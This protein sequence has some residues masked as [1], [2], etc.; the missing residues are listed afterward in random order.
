MRAL[1]LALLWSTAAYADPG[2]YRFPALHEQTIVFTA[3]G[4]L[5]VAELPASGAPGK[6]QARRLTT[7]PAEESQAVISDDGKSIAFVASY[8]GARDTY[9]M[10]ITGGEPKRISFDAARV[11]PQAFATIDGKA[12][13]LQVRESAPGPTWRRTLQWIDPQ[14]LATEEIPLADVTDAAL[15]PSGE[16][17]FTR[18]GLQV[19]GDN[20]RNYR[21]GALSEL[22]RFSLGSQQEAVRLP[23]ELGNL[24]RPMLAGDRLLAISDR[25]GVANLVSVSL[26]GSEVKALTQH[27]ALEVRAASYSEGRVLYQWGADLRLLEL[28]SG[29]DQ[30]LELSLSSDFEQ[31]R[32]RHL[33]QALRFYGGASLAP[34]GRRAWLLA[35]GIALGA[36]AQAM[37]RITLREAS[38]ARLREAV[39]SYDGKHVYAI[40]DRDGGTEVQRFAASGGTGESVFESDAHI[41]RLHIA[42]EDAG[43]IAEDKQARLIWLDLKSGKS[44]TLEQYRGAGDQPYQDLSFSSDGKYLVYARPNSAA[45]RSQIVVRALADN[46]SWVL[47]S[48]RYESFAPVFSRDGRWLYFLS[49]RHFQPSP[50]SPWGDRNAGTHFDKRSKVYALA[51][52]ADERFAFAPDTELLM[53]EAVLDEPEAP[54]LDL[55]NAKDRLYEV[56]IA[57]ANYRALA[58]DHERLYLLDSDANAEGSFKLMSLALNN[59]GE[60]TATVAEGLIGFE[61]SANAERILLIKRGSDATAPQM[62]GPMYLVD[63][64]ATATLDAKSE[65]KLSNWQLALSPKAEWQQMFLDAWRMHQQFSFDPAMRGVDW[66]L[67]RE[68]YAPLAARVTDRAELDDVLAQMAAELGIL[69][70]QVRGAEHRSDPEPAPP[71]SLGAVYEIAD[72]GV[73]ISHIYQSDPE[74]PSERAP[75]SQPGVDARVGDVITHVN[76]TPV[77]TPGDLVQ[78]LRT[79]AGMQVRLELKRGKELL[80]TVVVPVTMDREQTLRYQDWVRSR[81]DYLGRK[82]R[83]DIG[84]LHLRAMTASDMAQFARDYYDQVNR[85]GLIIDVRRNRGGNIDSWI[86]NALLRRTWAFWQPPLSEPYWNMQQSFRGHVVVLCDQLT[87]SDGETFSAGVKALAIGPLIGKRTA[88]AGIWLGDR[89]RLVDGGQA[90]V[91]EFGQFDQNGRWLIEGRGV[92]PDVEIENLPWATGM[93]GDAQLDHAIKLLEQRIGEHAIT[94]PP[95]QA[96]PAR[97]TPGHDGSS[98]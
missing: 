7:H 22:W 37:R 43:L 17:Y 55:S 91:A 56:P 52:A 66:Q 73:R 30:V 33:T 89:N 83:A 40:A 84:Y 51:L 81:F 65:L 5:W 26:D 36:S 24:S 28:A 57:A 61:L 79:Q 69:H 87:Y 8:D 42:P 21:G 2:Y 9:V 88:G 77:R 18:F 44:K 45:R 58:I 64:G 10:P 31:A 35:R 80:S 78:S 96:I 29:R 95:A 85:K 48:D 98:G 32:E 4:D 1:A 13:V 49:N 15:S 94:Q 76:Q 20:V 74:L 6:I 14:T 46:S 93:G 3:E 86:L 12:R 60:P 23:A 19:T 54:A 67:V 34:D 39:Q 38:G 97:G 71:A 63:A 41:W 82:T 92:A 16:L 59:Q 70:S 27:E 72:A 50:G 11:W 90:R 62:P 68:R 25:D 75:L 47:T 53:E